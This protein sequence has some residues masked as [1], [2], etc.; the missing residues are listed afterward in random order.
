MRGLKTS[1]LPVLVQQD[2]LNQHSQLAAIKTNDEEAHGL[3]QTA[4]VSGYTPIMD[5][6]HPV[7]HQFFKCC[8]FYRPQKMTNTLKM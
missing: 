5:S 7:S 2:I 1:S 3:V 4:F 8:Y 6:P